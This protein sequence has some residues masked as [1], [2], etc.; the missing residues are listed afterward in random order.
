MR[1]WPSQDLAN[2][3]FF[4]IGLGAYAASLFSLLMV[5]I[6]IA[7]PSMPA[8]K[9]ASWLQ[10]LAIVAM[11]FGLYAAPVTFYWGLWT[12]GR[13]HGAISWSA[14]VA[15]PLAAALWLWAFFSGG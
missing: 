3:P 1:R 15:G 5:A 8:G 7:D 13:V 4:W 10:L 6:A 14:V 9:A 2:R 12:G 11:E